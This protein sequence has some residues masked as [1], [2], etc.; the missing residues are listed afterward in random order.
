MIKRIPVFLYHGVRECLDDAIQ[1]VGYSLPIASIE[2]QIAWLRNGGYISLSLERL[3]SFPEEWER[4][5]AI[6]VDDCLMSAYT[7]LFPLL[8]KEGYTAC[9]F[10]IVNAVGQ[11]GWVG[12]REIAE[13]L[14]AGMEIGSHGLSH[15]DLSEISPSELRRELGDS[16]KI[17]EDTLGARVR[18]LSLP[19]GYCNRL[20]TTSAAEEGYEAVCSSAFGYNKPG[21]DRYALKRFCL[22]GDDATPVMRHIM[23]RSPLR[24]STLYAMEWGKGCARKIFGKK[25]Y[26]AIR[27]IFLPSDVPRTLPRF[28]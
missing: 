10:P 23:K 5:F 9:F 14:Q 16:K 20:V 26:A 3:L 6:T 11:K 24:L 22:R 4:S 7:H 13:M 28:P 27:G 12:W 8:R 2:S 25:I 15:A 19:G 1:D 18:Y 21:T 17:I